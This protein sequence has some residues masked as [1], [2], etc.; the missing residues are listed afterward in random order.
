MPVFVKALP[1]QLAPQALCCH[2]K[3]DAW[4][5][6]ITAQVPQAPTHTGR[7]PSLARNKEGQRGPLYL[8]PHW[9]SFVIFPP[10]WGSNS[11][12]QY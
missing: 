8:K 3:G 6:K 12:A 11:S 2:L 7:S 5:A 4:S 9:P 10:A 1:I